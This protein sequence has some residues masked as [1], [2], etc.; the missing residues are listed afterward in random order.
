MSWYS[1]L[2]SISSSHFSRTSILS[3]LNWIYNYKAKVNLIS[4]L[5]VVSFEVENYPG[6]LIVLAVQCGQE[7]GECVCLVPTENKGWD[8]ECWIMS[9]LISTEMNIDGGFGSH[10]TISQSTSTI[11]DPKLLL[12]LNTVSEYDACQTPHRPSHTPDV[13]L[14]NWSPSAGLGSVIVI[15][16]SMVWFWHNTRT[17]GDQSYIIFFSK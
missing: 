16:S 10:W 6:L 1:F 2:G 12:I 3:S 13:G 5:T 11:K 7:V 4:Y 14:L 15:L 17:A 9:C 8:W